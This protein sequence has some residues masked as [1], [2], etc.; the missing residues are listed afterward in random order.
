MFTITILETRTLNVSKVVKQE[1]GGLGVN[2]VESGGRGGDGVITRF[3]G[4]VNFHII[5]LFPQ[6]YFS[7]QI[8]PRTM[9]LFF[10]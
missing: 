8:I 5:I 1:N 3:H 6:Y 10:I 7:V 9:P 2:I 4:I